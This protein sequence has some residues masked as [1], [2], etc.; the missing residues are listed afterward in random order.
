MKVVITPEIYKLN[1]HECYQVKV[2]FADYQVTRVPGG[3][4]YNHPRLDSGQMNTI[5]VPY[6]KEF[7][8]QKIESK[9]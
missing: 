3:W 7:L 6:S 2:G 8:F 4:I 5:F 1:L 9:E